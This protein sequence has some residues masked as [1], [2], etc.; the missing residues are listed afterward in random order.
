[1]LKLMRQGQPLPYGTIYCCGGKASG[2]TYC[3]CLFTSYL[4]YYDIS[5]II[6]IFRKETQKISQTV[7]EVLDRLDAAG[8]KY[9]YLQEQEYNY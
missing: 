3:I 7:D 1:M 8:F 4:F 2:K 6:L 9:N 5:A